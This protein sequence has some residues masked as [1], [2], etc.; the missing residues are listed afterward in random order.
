MEVMKQESMQLAFIGLGN[1]GGP[2][3]ENLL[4]AGYE[5]GGLNRS[6]GRE[7]AFAEVGGRVGR[8]LS[9]LAAE[10]DVVMTCLP[11]P[12]DVEHVYLGTEGIVANGSPRLVMVDFSTVSPA[13]NKRIAAAAAERGMQYLDAP[14]SGGTVGAR[15]GTL[16]VMVGGDEPAY[17]KVKQLL[18]VLGSRIHY[19][20]PSGSGSAVKL[21]NQLMVGIH[22]Q[23]VAESFRLAERAGLPPAQVYDILS[24][25]FAQSR[26]MDRHYSQYMTADQYNAGF[27][28]KL[29][30]KDVDLVARMA[31]ELGASLP[32]GTE[33]LG[34]LRRA[35]ETE[36]AERDMSALYKF[37]QERQPEQR[38]NYFAV[39]LPMR[40]EELSR[41]HRPEHLAYLEQMRRQ[42]RIFVNGRFVDGAGGLVIYKAASLEEARAIVEND[43]YV[44]H[45]ARDYEIHEW[46][47]VL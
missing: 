26:I 3:A 30:H 20:G 27:A 5:V 24:G 35:K 31:D 21:L 15:E 29:L 11:L 16:T 39:F 42:G 46:D 45:R 17:R 14:V 32:L 25:S 23:A 34:I 13:L 36:W 44:R 43:P 12:E 41:I 18:D 40:D 19:V 2:M 6:K 22:S 8:T 38:Y 37:Q 1:M 47:L 4:K 28:L 33:V 9:E 7:R 10:V